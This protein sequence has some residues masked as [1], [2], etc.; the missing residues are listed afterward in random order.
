MFHAAR[1]LTGNKYIIICVHYKFC[2]IVI[3]YRYFFYNL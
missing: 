3:K 2:V 1:K